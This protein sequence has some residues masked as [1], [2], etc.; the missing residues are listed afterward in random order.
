VPEALIIT[1]SH[2]IRKGAAANLFA[3]GPGPYTGDADG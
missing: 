2:A 1:E 3:D